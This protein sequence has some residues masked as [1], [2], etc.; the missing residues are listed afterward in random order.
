MQHLFTVSQRATPWWGGKCQQP[1]NNMRNT[2][3]KKVTPKV[4]PVYS[5]ET[6]QLLQ[7]NY[8]QR[9]AE[10]HAAREAANE[11]LRMLR[12]A[13]KALARA[14]SE[15]V[16]CTQMQFVLTGDKSMPGDIGAATADASYVEQ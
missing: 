3:R 8:Q 5:R 9:F 12:S 4:P 2:A 11:A 14:A 6:H 15:Y 1:V 7:R 10:H 13:E 16:E